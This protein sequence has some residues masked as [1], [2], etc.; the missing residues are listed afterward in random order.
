MC[1]FGNRLQNQSVMTIG[2]DTLAQVEE[3]Q[4]AK[5]FKLDD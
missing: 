4:Y 1:K 2:D 3:K 5:P